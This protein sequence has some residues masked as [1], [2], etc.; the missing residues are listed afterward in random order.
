MALGNQDGYR[1]CWRVTTGEVVLAVAIGSGGEW[2][3]GVSDDGY[4][5]CFG[6]DGRQL[7]QA[8]IGGDSGDVAYAESAKVFIASSR[9]NGSLLFVDSTGTLLDTWNLG[10]SGVWGIACTPDAETIAVGLRSGG[11]R[12]LDAMRREEK[13]RFEEE[14]FIWHVGLCPDARRIV[15]ASRG[16][17]AILL[18]WGGRLVWKLDG[19]ED[20]VGVAISEDGRT[21]VAGDWDSTLH[22]VADDRSR[23]WRYTTGGKSFKG[24][25]MTPRADYIVAA[26]ES[27]PDA[28]GAAY[29]FDGTGNLM[30]ECPTAG[31]A[32]DTAITPDGH[33]VAAGSQTGEILLL[34]NLLPPVGA[35]VA[36]EGPFAGAIARSHVIRTITTGRPR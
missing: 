2:V 10:S 21:V 27:G 1:V 33:F 8:P 19:S 3:A 31:N 5:H 34:E 25:A 14:S 36:R 22:C 20:F 29:L 30:W 17:C 35:S 11:I 13:W 28:E 12:F 6:Q 32:H 9:D 4:L 7:W 24:L 23:K 15:A 18:D 16:N 26:G